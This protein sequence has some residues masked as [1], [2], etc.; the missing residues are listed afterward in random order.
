MKIPTDPPL[1]LRLDPME[2]LLSERRLNAEIV[3]PRVVNPLGG[4][5]PLVAKKW[6][7]Q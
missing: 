5:L 1:G 4:I 3:M 2:L 6:L 7:A